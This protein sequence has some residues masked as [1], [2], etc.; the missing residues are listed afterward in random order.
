MLYLENILI[1]S[2]DVQSL[3]ISW[4]IVS[5]TETVSGYGLDIYRSENPVWIAEDITSVVSGIYL[6]VETDYTDYTISGLDI[7]SQWSYRNYFLQVRNLTTQVVG[8]MYGPY[9]MET[10]RDLTAQEIIRN[11]NITL[12]STYGG[13]PFLV[14]KRKTNGQ[15]CTNCY[16]EITSRRTEEHC[17]TCYDTKWVGGYWTPIQIQGMM[18]AAPKRNQIT[19]WGEWQAS[20]VI[21]TVSN[22]PIL[23]PKDII[24]DKL[25]RRWLVI[26]VRT[27]EKGLYILSQQAQLRLI[28]KGDVVY[29]F[30]VSN[31]WS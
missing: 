20:D 26:Q 15:E 8:T 7:T 31:S 18:N 17:N 24:V 29:D 30:D 5:T 12:R 25:N 9:K 4:D 23:V 21:L 1:S 27:V 19:V 28:V 14:L 13:R 3:N 22:Y 16:E 6:D 10:A 2:Y 11:H